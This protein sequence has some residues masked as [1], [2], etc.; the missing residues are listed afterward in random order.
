M[1]EAATIQDPIGF[2]T[3][4]CDEND[5]PLW[6]DELVEAVHRYRYYTGLL[7]LVNDENNGTAWVDESRS[8]RYSFDF[9]ERERERID[10]SLQF[11]RQVLEAS[12]AKRVYQTDVLSTHVQGSCRMGSDPQRSVV[13]AHA[14]CH[15]V[16]RLFV[17]DSSVVPRTLSVNPS[18][19]IMALAS[20]LAE[21]LDAGEHG[22]FRHVD[23][24]VSGLAFRH[25]HDLV[26]ERDPLALD[27]VRPLRVLGGSRLE[28]AKQ[29]RLHRE[30]GVRV[31]ILAGGVEDVGRQRPVTRAR[32][33]SC[34]CARGAMDDARWLRASSRPARRRGSCTARAARPRTRS[35]RP[36]GSGSGRAGG[37][38]APRDAAP[39]T[40]DRRRSA[41][42][43]ARRRR[44]GR[45]SRSSTRPWTSTGTPVVRLR[46]RC[47]RRTRAAASPGRRT[48]RAPSTRWRR[49][50]ARGRA[51]RRASTGRACPT[52]G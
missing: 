1:I 29:R 37:P 34:G 40:A 16:R 43:R 32:S 5:R 39:R 52:T 47:S 7:T 38:R 14:E 36:R 4:L 23:A 22:Y 50:G 8:D 41:R 28:L 11:A 25:E 10:R 44:S 21:Y 45:R 24:A 12:G 13:D 17:G 18:L 33:R 2:A 26:L 27:A 31:E 46:Q 48:G 19:T 3:G 6:G 51:R 35:C 9:N 20:R 30:H 42:R 49:R 15:D